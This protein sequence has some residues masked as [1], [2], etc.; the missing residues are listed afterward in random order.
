MKKEQL[1]RIKILSMML[2]HCDIIDKQINVTTS[3][4]TSTMSIRNTIEFLLNKE[5]KQK[6]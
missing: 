6:L 2:A 4:R 5:R 3:L 1:E